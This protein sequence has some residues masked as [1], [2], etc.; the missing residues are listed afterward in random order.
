[1]VARVNASNKT[2]KSNRNWTQNP[3]EVRSDILNVAMRVFAKHGLSG[4]RIDEIAAATKTSKRMIYYYFGD[5]EGLYKHALEAAYAKIRIGEENLVL[6]NMPARKALKKLI[7]FTFEHHRKHPDFIRIVQVENTH[8]ARYLQESK[9]LRVLNADVIERLSK[10][11]LQGER[12]GTFRSGI[13]PVALHWHISA[14]SFFNVS[15][16]E[17][18][19][20]SF[21]ATIF[22]AQWQKRLEDD[23]TEMILNYV[24]AKPSE[25]AAETPPAANS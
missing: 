20:A 11:I 4:A 18:F 10:I 14:M 21:G 8:N 23:A 13:H 15:N 6:N 5:K 25:K 2:T 1:M 3:R 24:S 9:H 19:S 7:H 22:S 17:S 12:E 16:R